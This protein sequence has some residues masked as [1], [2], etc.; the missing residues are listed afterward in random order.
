MTSNQPRKALT[1]KDDSEIIGIRLPKDVA[2]D[3]KQEVA[4]RGMKINRFFLELW[5][6]Y[7]K[8]KRK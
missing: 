7:K 4:R 5:N 8:T 3:V 2:I 1:S 6:D